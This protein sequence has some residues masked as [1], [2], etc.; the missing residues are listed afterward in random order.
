M[1]DRQAGPPNSAAPLREGLL[2]L[3]AQACTCPAS[4]KHP[5]E[6]HTELGA[7]HYM[8]HLPS[9]PQASTTPSPAP[10]PAPPSIPAI[11]P[12]HHLLPDPR[13][14]ERSGLW[15]AAGLRYE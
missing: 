10:P 12:T 2:T 5:Q 9:T 1:L 11:S 8:I 14:R 6:A 13:T 15:T 7:L 4:G 3:W